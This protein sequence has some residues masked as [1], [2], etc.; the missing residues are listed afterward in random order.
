[1]K[2]PQDMILCALDSKEKEFKMSEEINLDFV[3]PNKDCNTCD[4]HNF[5]TCFECEWIQVK[6]KYN[7][8]FYTDDCEWILK[9]VNNE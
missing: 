4:Y 1:M 2:I 3:K 6:D 5:Y 8:S 7:N 9:E